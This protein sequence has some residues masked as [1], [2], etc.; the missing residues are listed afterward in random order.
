MNWIQ[1]AQWVA[2]AVGVVAGLYIGYQEIKERRARIRGLPPNPERCQKH[3]DRIG[4]VEKT[5]F[6]MEAKMDGLK[7]NVDEIKRDVKELIS[8]HLTK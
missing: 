1:W 5:C 2:L 8:L 6:S 7:E 4:E 3:E